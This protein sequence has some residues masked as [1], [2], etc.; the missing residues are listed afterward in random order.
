MRAVLHA[1]FADHPAR[2]SRRPDSVSL[3][4]PNPQLRDSSVDEFETALIKARDAW[5]GRR[6]HILRNATRHN[7]GAQSR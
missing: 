4:R 3:T 6:S 2:L 1:K 7:L 5:C